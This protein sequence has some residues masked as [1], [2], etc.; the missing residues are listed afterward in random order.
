MQKDFI[1]FTNSK[2]STDQNVKCKTVKLLEIITKES[3]HDFRYGDAFLILFI[4]VLVLIYL[5]V[6]G[7]SCSMWDLLLPFI[8]ACWLLSSCGRGLVTPQD[9]GSYFLSQGSNLCSLHWKVYF[10]FSNSLLFSFYSSHNRT[11]LHTE[12]LASVK[13]FDV[14]QAPFY[15]LK[16]CWHQNMTVNQC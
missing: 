6:S 14:G 9:V 3:L 1:T 5:A 7:L 16:L 2:G 10:F 15:P 13:S 8:A 12:F 4:Y 11:F